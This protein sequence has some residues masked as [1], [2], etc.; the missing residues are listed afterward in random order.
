MILI[1]EN[2]GPS[3]ATKLS[4]SIEALETGHE[5]AA[6]DPAQDLNGQEEGIAGSHPSGVIG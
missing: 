1:L 2:C 4:V 5:L 3:G 6:A